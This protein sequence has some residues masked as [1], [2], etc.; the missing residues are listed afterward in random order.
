V[1]GGTGRG[2]G[3]ERWTKAMKQIREGRKLERK[4]KN[5]KSGYGQERR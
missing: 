3:I 2:K 1:R 5:G 4:E